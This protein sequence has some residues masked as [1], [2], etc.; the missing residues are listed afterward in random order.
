[1]SHVDLASRDIPFTVSDI[2]AEAE[3]L[4]DSDKPPREPH[5]SRGHVR[6]RW[7]L[8]VLFWLS[9]HHGGS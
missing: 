4:I 5:T 6:F 3:E 9:C 1:M 7:P 8:I 2:T